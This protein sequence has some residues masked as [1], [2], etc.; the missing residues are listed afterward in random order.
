ML[1]GWLIYNKDSAKENNTYIRWFIHEASRQNIELQLVLRES[2]S[3]GIQNGKRTTYID[4]KNV[5]L[6][7]FL[8]IRVIEPI[9][10]AHFEACFI[11]TFNCS[12]TSLIC[13]HKS[14]TYMEMNK[15]HVPI[16]PTFF[17]TKNALPNKLPIDY[18]IVVKEATGRSGKQVHF[19]Q[20]K[21]DWEKC[22]ALLETNE[23]L[24]QATNVNLGEDLRVFVVGKE[25]V[26]AVL[27]KNEKDFRSNFKLG[28]KAI[29]YSLSSEQEKLIHKII[30]HFDFGLVGIDF[31]INEHGEL[32]FNE[33][34][35]VV[36]SRI[37]SK[38]SD[39]NLLEKY[40][41]FIKKRVSEIL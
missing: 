39:V 22:I 11:P 25:I 23:F 9:L 21:V 10:Q 14:W 17:M 36:G 31:L 5:K 37:L 19:V 12:T 6:P 30:N 16:V 29:P 3:I 13:N 2:L 18:P 33:I 41:S 40:V 35:D 38:V 34:E 27:R 15:L 20:D 24:I 4:G 32:L 1:K 8:I 26:G 28:G 7:D